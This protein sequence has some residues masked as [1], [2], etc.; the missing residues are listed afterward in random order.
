MAKKK[1]VDRMLT[2]REVA[3]RL[4]AGESS[5]RIWAAEGRFPGAKR[6]E[7]PAGSPYWLIPEAAL[8]GFIKRDAGRPPKPKKDKKPGEKKET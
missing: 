1:G 8:D 4:G 6:E 3:S 5:I 7:P 2:V